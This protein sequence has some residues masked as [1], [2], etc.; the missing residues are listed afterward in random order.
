M[1]PGRSFAG[2][3]TLTAELVRAGATYYSDEY[4]L[5]DAEGLIHPHARDLQMRAP[6]QSEQRA[7]GVGELGG[8]CGVAGIAAGVILFVEYRVGAEWSPEA[9]TPAKATLEMMLHTAAVRRIPAR[10]MEMLARVA[11]AAPAFRS[12]RGE[13]AEAA[14]AILAWV[15]DAR[16]R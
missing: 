10:T 4:A 1:L 6:G 7:L 12:F 13:A 15:A 16:G 8:A 3:T 9:V 5:L 2:K 11:Q 14:R